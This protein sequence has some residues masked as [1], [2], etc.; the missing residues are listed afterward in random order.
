[1][2][3]HAA[4]WLIPKMQDIFFVSI[5][6]AGVLYGPKLFNIDGDLGRHITVGNYIIT[7][8]VIPTKDIFSHTM[9]GETLV[10]HEWLSEVIFSIAYSL[11]GLNGVVLLTATII[12]ITFTLSFHEIIG[13]GAF[14]LVALFTALV[15]A[16][17][18]S[19]HWLARP[20]IFT[21][22]FLAL[23]IYRLEH[24]VE[25]KNERIWVF[26]LL[27]LVW[28]NSHGAFIVGF[29]VW[30]AYVA[31]WIW[32]FLH[33]QADEQ[34]GRSLISIG[35]FSFIATLFNPSGYKLWATSIGYIRNN[36]LVDH[37]VEYM[38]PNFHLAGTL[39]FLFM[40]AFLI[41]LSGQGTQLKLRESILLAGWTIMALYS[42]RNIPLFAIVNAPLLGILV[43]SSIGRVQ[44]LTQQ[45]ENLRKIESQLQGS[46]YPITA[47]FLIIIAFNSGIKL[48]SAQLG[49][50][51]DPTIFPEHAVNWLEQNPQKGNV[52]NSFIWGGYLLYREWPQINVFIDGQTDFY[53]ETLTREYEQAIS[54]TSGWENIFTKYNIEWTIL[55]NKSPLA[56]A[57]QNNYHWRVLY[58]DDLAVILHK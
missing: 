31:E 9:S 29:V 3:L 50:R 42:A 21:F 28:A 39:P 35:F 37:T 48:D 23:W 40:L 30:G 18:S 4:R 47:I 10:P 51:Y 12:S 22:L 24:V 27:M 7:N 5:L 34:K 14:H 45:N 32:E 52:F 20:H 43:Q 2:K 38:T 25:K 53:G 16:M 26:P 19:L 49:N 17:A 58:E 15:A 54:T 44:F 57:L 6:F 56:L 1:M 41:F 33:N 8:Q 46:V 11:M 36:Y 55:E 13:R